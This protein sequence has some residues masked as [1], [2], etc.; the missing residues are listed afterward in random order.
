VAAT[1]LV[2]LVGVVAL[3]RLRTRGWLETRAEEAG[4]GGL[5]VAGA[6]AT[7]L[8]VPVIIVDVLGGFPRDINVAL[9]EALLFYPSIAF[10]AE[11]VFHVVP[12]AALLGALAPAL[13]GLGRERTLW[14]CI[15]LAS[16]AEPIFQVLMARGD[17]PGWAVTYLG[18]HL[19]AFGLVALYLFK[20]YDFMTMYAFR[21][22]YYVTWHILWG[23]AR[24]QLLF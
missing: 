3:H 17:S 23:F 18:L 21:A 20:K 16:A 19:S 2:A 22:T 7:L 1:A 10:V 9:P 6:L 13:D 24:L 5:P 15:L 8:T 12:L 14:T 11:I 4:R